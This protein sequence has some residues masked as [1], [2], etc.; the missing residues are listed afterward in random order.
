MC[1]LK[2]FV[3]AIMT[4]TC[5][6][7]LGGVVQS[8]QNFDS[9]SH[10]QIVQQEQFYDNGSDSGFRVVGDNFRDNRDWIV[11]FDT[12]G[13]GTRDSDLETPFESGNLVV[14]GRSVD[15]DGNAVDFNDALIIQER[16]CR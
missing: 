13:N 6:C 16:R 7:S 8:V 12:N 10:G 5:A 11:A 2:H 9:L 4:M 1:F 14:N 3:F 15:F